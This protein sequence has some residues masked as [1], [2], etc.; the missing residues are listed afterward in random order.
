MVRLFVLLL[1]LL[2]AVSPAHGDDQFR[3]RP[4]G[5]PPTL[6]ASADAVVHVPPTSPP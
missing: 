6:E 5:A 2:L 4:P 1:P 3:L